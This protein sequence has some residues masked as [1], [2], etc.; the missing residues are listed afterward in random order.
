MTAKSVRKLDDDRP[1]REDTY[2]RWQEEQG[3]SII[4]GLFVEDVKKIE[5]KGSSLLLFV[6]NDN[7]RSRVHPRIP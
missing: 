1:G 6:V 7:P 3:M 4:R 5:R 2:H